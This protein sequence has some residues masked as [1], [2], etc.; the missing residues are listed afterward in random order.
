MRR[1]LLRK[2]STRP[3][4]PTTVQAT[5][6]WAGHLRNKRV[7]QAEQWQARHT[8]DGQHMHN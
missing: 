3:R 4:Q 8:V 1:P 2:A 6:L 7:R 5:H